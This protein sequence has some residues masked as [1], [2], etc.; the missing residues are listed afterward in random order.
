MT[1]NG[2]A[3]GRRIPE[4]ARPSGA[5]RAFGLLRAV[6][7]L[8]PIG[9]GADKFTNLLTD[10]EQYLAPSIASWLPIDPRTALLDVGLVEIGAGLVVL[11]A[12]RVG[13]LVVA[14]WLWAIAVNLLLVPLA[15]IA[16][17]DL[18]LS[19][20][21][22]ALTFLA[23][24]R[25]APPAAPRPVT[26]PRSAVLATRGL[27]GMWMIDYAGPADRADD[28][29]AYN[30]SLLI[31]RTRGELASRAD[32]EA[33][34]FLAINLANEILR[35]ARTPE[36]ARLVHAQAVQ[37]A[38]HPQYKYSFLFPVARVTQADP[39]QPL[40]PAPVTPLSVGSAPSVTSSAADRPL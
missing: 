9:A 12:P 30:G 7:T 6:F 24:D 21:A 39:D 1:T 29:L 23:A 22:L 35:G 37:Q 40:V 18:G 11:I 38:Q 13:G 16:V 27:A 2:A 19:A 34:N 20:G 28:L 26:A 14:A 3:A 8:L 15:D 4:P 17:R 31:D 25:A 33:T 10:W 36:E 32:S 5:G